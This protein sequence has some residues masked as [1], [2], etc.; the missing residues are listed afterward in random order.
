M[1]SICP[2]GHFAEKGWA[3]TTTAQ[4]TLRRPA[5]GRTRP[6]PVTVSDCGREVPPSQHGREHRYLGPTRGRTER[7]SATRQMSMSAVRATR[8]RQQ[9]QSISVN[10]GRLHRGEQ[11]TPIGD[12]LVQTGGLRVSGEA[13]QC[14]AGVLAA[15]DVLPCA[16]A[17]QWAP[18]ASHPRD[19]VTARGY[20]PEAHGGAGAVPTDSVQVVKFA[21]TWFIAPSFQPEP[22]SKPQ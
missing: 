2:L 15:V 20:R 1:S 13:T 10:S 8:R 7:S 16:A 18:G 14:R 12:R 21:N 9:H 5:M 17:P 11:I 22:S 4:S 3:T 19:A 6:P